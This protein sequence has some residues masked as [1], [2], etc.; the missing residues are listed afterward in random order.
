MKKQIERFIALATQYAQVVKDL[1]YPVGEFIKLR[2]NTFTVEGADP[3]GIP[4]DE[5][6][7]RIYFSDV[8]VQ[9]HSDQWAFSVQD[10]KKDLMFRVSNYGKKVEF[11]YG[12]TTRMIT[13]MCDDIEGD[14]KHHFLPLVEK[15]KQQTI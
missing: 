1:N 11:S 9:T 15:R 10:L 3:N 12:V 14:L 13:R 7:V 8:I 6:K 2:G 4:C 5:F